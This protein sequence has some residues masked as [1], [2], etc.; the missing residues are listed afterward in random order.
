MC[1]TSINTRVCPNG[2]SCKNGYHIKGTV[3]PSL[4]VPEKE[5]VKEKVQNRRSKEKEPEAFP[6]L[7]TTNPPKGFQDASPFGEIFCSKNS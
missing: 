7:Q 2:K 6:H 1:F 4:K 3:E 5:K